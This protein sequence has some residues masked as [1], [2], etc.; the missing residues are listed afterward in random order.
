MRRKEQVVAQSSSSKKG[1]SKRLEDAYQTL[2]ENLQD[3]QHSFAAGTNFYKA[4]WIF[5]I[6][7]LI[8]CVFETVLCLIQRGHYENRVGL[9]YG[10]FI[11]IYGIGMVLC[12]YLFRH[13]KNPFKVFVIA[14]F[15]GGAFEYI[16]S[17]LQ[18]LLFGT[19]SWDYSKYFLN[20]GGRTSV[21]HAMWWGVAGLIIVFVL[22]PV[23]SKGIEKIPNKIGYI[24]SW[25]CIILI[26]VDVFLS[27]AASYR[28]G[29]RQVGVPAQNAFAEFLD[30]HYPDQR[31]DAI[32]ANKKT[33]KVNK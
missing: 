18:E 12:M 33:V 25:I 10:P 32:F 15:A 9:I 19:V 13:E 11:P 21:Y 5:V 29:Q 2:Q 16:C 3:E 6:G 26:S 7:S 28:Q 14:A 8:G 31:L 17:Y 1:K 23:C 30:R 4:F 20:F 22:Y 27:F 24:V